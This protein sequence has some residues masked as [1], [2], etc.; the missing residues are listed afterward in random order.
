MVDVEEREAGVVENE[1]RDGE[2]EVV[3]IEGEVR[4]GADHHCTEQDDDKVIVR[5]MKAKRR[6]EE[7]TLTQMRAIPL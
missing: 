6:I 3:A 7:L 1:A 5:R 4:A 2:S